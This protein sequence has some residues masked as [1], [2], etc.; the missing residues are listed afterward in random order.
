M[1]EYHPITQRIIDRTQQV[2]DYYSH[3]I[4]K[5]FYRDNQCWQIVGF[6][7]LSVPYAVK[8]NNGRPQKTQYVA[9]WFDPTGL[10]D[11]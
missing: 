3:H 11:E 8:V 9:D 5:R 7:D 10:T 2:N 6:N 4:G 1:T